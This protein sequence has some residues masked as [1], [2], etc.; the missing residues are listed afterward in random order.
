MIKRVVFDIDGTLQSRQN[1]LRP[2]CIDVMNKLRDAGII[3]SVWSG[4]GIEYCRDWIDRVDPDNAIGIVAYSKIPSG[5]NRDVAVVDDDVGVVD[6]SECYRA[7]AI[8]VPTYLGGSD[9]GLA[10]VLDKLLPR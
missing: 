9:D 5:L 1:E 7:V 2:G 3:V 4:N 8:L 6:I 10:A